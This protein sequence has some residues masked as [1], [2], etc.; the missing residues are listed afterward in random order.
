M[1]NISFEPNNFYQFDKLGYLYKNNIENNKIISDH[2]ISIIKTYPT[3]KQLK[4]IEKM[5]LDGEYERAKICMDV[6]EINLH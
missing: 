1:N 5:I 3:N 2:M 4:I 6:L